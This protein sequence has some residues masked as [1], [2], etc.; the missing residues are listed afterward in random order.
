[1]TEIEKT[2][3]SNGAA[4][5]Q[6]GSN[7]DVSK[8]IIRQVEYYFGDWNLPRDKFLQEQLK[9]NEDGW[10]GIDVMLKFQ[11]L[12]KICGD[13]E[14]ILKA[15]KGSTEKLMEV[16]LENKKIRR[17]P[18]IPLPEKEDEEAKK[19]KTVYAKNFEKEATTL[20][21]LLDYFKQYDNV[22]HVNR[23]TWQDQKDKSRHFKGSV[24]VTFKDKESAEKFMALESV[25]SPEGVELIRKWQSDYFKE[26]EDEYKSKKEQRG[27]DKKSKKDVQKQNEKDGEEEKTE[28]ENALPKGAVMFMDGFKD[29]TMREDIKKV[30][31]C[32]DAIAFIDFEKGKTSGYIRFKEEN[33]AKELFEKLQEKYKDDEKLKVKEAEITYKV[34]EGDDESQYLVKAANDIKQRQNKFRHGHK[35]KGGFRGG[36][37]GKRGRY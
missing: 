10:I 27:K 36:R 33:A 35:R 11:R 34:L 18:E 5:A 15:L 17:N 32:D 4:E 26:K 30:L 3:A 19:A 2:E 6:N 8:Q 14:T 13:G 22:I 23:R 31:D 7:A 20:D 24:F 25:K 16:D 28:P 1:M 12:N 29:D 37:G 21:D 9:S